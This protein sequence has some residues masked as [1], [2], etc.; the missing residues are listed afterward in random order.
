MA[1]QHQDELL[2]NGEPGSSPQTAQDE[3]PQPM[4]TV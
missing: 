1:S 2:V 4:A 3:V